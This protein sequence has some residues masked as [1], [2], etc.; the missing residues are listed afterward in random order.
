MERNALYEDYQGLVRKLLTLSKSSLFPT[1]LSRLPVARLGRRK[2]TRR[3]IRGRSALKIHARAGN[4]E[5]IERP[6]QNATVLV[7]SSFTAG[8][9][10]AGRL[11]TSDIPHTRNLLE[12]PGP[13]V[14]QIDSGIGRAI[15]ERSCPRDFDHAGRWHGNASGEARVRDA[16]FSIPRLPAPV[17]NPSLGKTTERSAALSVAPNLGNV[18]GA[19]VRVYFIARFSRATPRPTAASGR[20][21]FFQNS[22]K[23]SQLGRFVVRGGLE[24]D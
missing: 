19:S 17:I 18:A 21:F 10:F 16:R 6:S 22:K 20:R 15:I 12:I 9:P 8:V 1:F 3:Q 5:N 14:G 11:E 4:V 7:T 23:D 13:N 24:L 2:N